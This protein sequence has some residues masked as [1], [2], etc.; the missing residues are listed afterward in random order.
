MNDQ[1]RGKLVGLYSRKRFFGQS[2]KM[3]CFCMKK[4]I[5]V[6]L[7]S[8][9][10]LLGTV[11]VFLLTVRVF[12][13]TR[14]DPVRKRLVWFLK[15]LVQ[16]AKRLV[17]FL[18]IPSYWSAFWSYCPVPRTIVQFSGAIVSFFFEFPANRV[19]LCIF[20]SDIRQ[21]IHLKKYSYSLNSYIFPIF[22]AHTHM[23]RLISSSY[24]QDP[25]AI[26]SFSSYCLVPRA[27]VQF[28]LT[29]VHYAPTGR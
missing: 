23:T 29:N 22:W 15:R 25:R 8:G 26:G 21:L 24:F 28:P 4:S 13:G 10:V 11:P 18:I 7:W 14:N 17:W 27:N 6:F 1:K 2:K 19:N 3:A 20:F 16:F 12:L 9:P 5:A